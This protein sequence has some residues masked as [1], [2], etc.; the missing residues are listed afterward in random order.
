MDLWKYTLTMIRN[1]QSMCM[2]VNVNNVYIFF[3]LWKNKLLLTSSIPNF[4]E[5][6]K[7][8]S[9]LLHNP[10]I[11]STSCIEFCFG[12]GTVLSATHERMNKASSLITKKL[13]S[14]HNDAYDYRTCLPGAYSSHVLENN[15]KITILFPWGLEHYDYMLTV[16][17]KTM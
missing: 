3:H 11:H 8:K 16:V 6:E 14:Y 1:E 7:S 9:T 2:S 15:V 10:F 5:K 13:Q 17:Y 12:S 4:D